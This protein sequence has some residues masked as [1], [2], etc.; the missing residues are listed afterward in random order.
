MH[1]QAL[2]SC[3]HPPACSL[4]LSTEHDNPSS[5][6][7]AVPLQTPPV[8]A[9]PEVHASPS[10]HGVVSAFV[11]FEQTPVDVLQVP[12]VWHWSSAV[13]VTATPLTHT[14]AWQVSF[15]VQALLSLQVVPSP[16]FWKAHTPVD[17]LH[18]PA[19]WHWSGAAQV[20]GLAPVQTPDKQLSVCVHLFPSS[21]LAPSA[22][23]EIG[24]AP[25]DLLHAPT[26]W[27]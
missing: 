1:G 25:V 24:Q 26:V 19:M 9:S 16:L 4:Q 22:F 7:T 11:G 15:C 3:T 5:Q 23:W 20:T 17:V 13:H 8:H 6:F 12:A 14:P 27:H 21:Q 18:T 10:L 2:L